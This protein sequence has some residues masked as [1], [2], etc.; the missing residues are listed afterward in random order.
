V[1]ITLAN[2]VQTLASN[3]KSKNSIFDDI[4]QK[5][6]LFTVTVMRSPNPNNKSQYLTTAFICYANAVYAGLRCCT[7]EVLHLFIHTC[8]ATT[9]HP[10]N[11][12]FHGP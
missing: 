5:I 7:A 2:K 6:D 8:N 3:Y 4:S 10:R 1:K 12:L 11:Q 9:M